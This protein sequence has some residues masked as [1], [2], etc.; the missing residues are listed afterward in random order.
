MW[1]MTIDEAIKHA[2]TGRN[3]C[4][5]HCSDKKHDGPDAV[6]WH[7]WARKEA[8]KEAGYG[9]QSKE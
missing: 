2:E 5:R 7:R 1:I 8:M 6:C 3:W 4:E 9:D